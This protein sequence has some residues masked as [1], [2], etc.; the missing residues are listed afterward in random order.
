M[1]LNDIRY[2]LR[3]F[4]KSPAFVTMAVLALAFG[5]G[6]NSVVF[7]FLNAFVLRPLPSVK[8]SDRV[9]MIESRRRGNIAGTSYADFADWQQ[10]ARAFSRMVAADSFSPIVTGRGE[11]ERVAGARVSQGFF[12][13]FNARPLQGRLLLPDDYAPGA[14][15][16]M[17]LAH[18]FWQRE[19][20][21]RPE[22]AGAVITADGVPYKVV[23]IL[24]AGFRYSWEDD[25]FFTPL[26]PDAAAATARG[27]RSLD[28]MA[29]L[30]PGVSIPAAQTEMGTIAKRLEIA[31]PATNAGVRAN[32]RSLISMLGEGPDQAIYMLMGVVGF[33]LLI[34]CANV[35]NLQLAR[36]T[37]REGE[38]AVRTAL[39]AGRAALMQLVLTESTVIAMVG[40]VIGV[41]L[42]WAGG[43]ILIAS[44]PENVQPINPDFF[45]TPVLAFTAI[46]ALV[47]GILAGIAPALRISKID[48]HSTLK[49]SGRSG[50]GSSSGGLRNVLVVAEVSLAIVLLLAA[51]L[52]IR[53]FNALQQIDPGFRVQGLLTAQVSL[54]PAR[55]RTADSRAALFRDLLAKIAA[56]PG[57]QSA[58]ASSSVPMV[59]GNATNFVIEGRPVAVSGAQNFALWRS[60]TVGYFQILGI[61]IHR[62][63]AFTDQDTTTSE[64]VAIINER[65]AHMYFPNED[66]LG[67]RIKWSRD[68]AS[69]AA[70]LTIVGVCGEVRSYQLGAQPTPEMFAPFAQRP[71]PFATLA[72]RT[73]SADPAP[74]AGAVRAALREVDRDQPITNVRSMR[75]VVNESM[76]EAKYVSGLTAL[77]ACIAMMLA[78]MGIYGVISYSVARRTHE[79]GIRMVLGAGASD[80]VRLV[81]RQAL[82]LVAIG[83]AI[84]VAGALAVSRLLSSWLYGVSPRDPLTFIG[85]PLTLAVV[86][87]LASFIPARRATGVDP[88]VAL[89]FE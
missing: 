52:L 74:I 18:R 35:A 7:S 34:A 16:V 79:L 57:V 11:P 53:S 82:T 2:A 67:K 50:S 72:I 71:Q 64:K 55:Y 15:T 68:P 32:V 4:S 26:A 30:K 89:R 56:I 77:F 45:D 47:T 48:I 42:S 1:L 22:A 28:I 83:L 5:I 3:L 23:G 6:A 37:G 12:D 85:A 51:G 44:L 33:V 9:V 36:A 39:G 76:T 10:Q 27:N 46:V 66:P 49:E 70:W 40:G 60:P 19:F 86:A 80:V 65:L 24:P 88:V 61:P 31:Y 41:A 8:D 87:L 29:R 21:G 59:S 20:G 58:V 73:Y 13:M 54:P 25:D 84:G 62:G 78:V 14:P 81:L 63:R 69:E 75:S 38:M 43:R 17:V